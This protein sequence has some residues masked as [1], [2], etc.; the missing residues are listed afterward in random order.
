MIYKKKNKNVLKVKDMSNNNKVNSSTQTIFNNKKNQGDKILYYK[1]P[2]YDIFS[3]SFEQKMIFSSSY[4]SIY[5]DKSFLDIS[6]SISRTPIKVD[7]SICR[8]CFQNKKK[9]KEIKERF[10][11]NK[12]LIVGKY[13]KFELDLLRKRSINIL[14]KNNYRNE[15]SQFL[16]YN[17]KNNNVTPFKNYL[18]K[19]RLKKFSEDIKIKEHSNNKTTRYQ[20]FDF[21][22][23]NS[24]N[25]EKVKNVF[26]SLPII[27][28]K[29]KSLS[30]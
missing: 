16:Y 17:I 9:K 28:I 26:N 6:N 13:S 18:M 8:N 10:N 1:R 12:L 20:K 30:D 29:N 7:I 14:K 27:K 3:S 23:R 4:K 15:T 11:K 19:S 25:K 24:I 22:S 2:T 5:N 21:Y